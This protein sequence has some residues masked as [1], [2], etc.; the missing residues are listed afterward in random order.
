VTARLR[1]PDA[2]NIIADARSIVRNIVALRH[3][4]S[5]S[6]RSYAVTLLTPIQRSLGPDLARHLKGLGI[7]PESPL[8]RVP[9]VHFARW[10]VI[11]QLKTDWGGAPSP[12]PRLNSEYL[13]F[14]AS[15]TVPEG[16]VGR[17]L[18]WFLGDLHGRIGPEADRIWRHCVGYPGL[19]DRDA[20]VAYLAKSQIETALFHV[21]YPDVGV[22]EIRRAL[23]VRDALVTFARDHQGDRDAGRIQDDYLRESEA[24]LRSS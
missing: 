9:S 15:V 20:F 18:A 6:G 13:L 17:A 22:D 24:W 10:L 4:G 7:G 19:E 23:A 2:R 11:D 14:T 5:V 16:E 21:G 12:P 1:L 8:A 3:G